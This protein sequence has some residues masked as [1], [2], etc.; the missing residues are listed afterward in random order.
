MPS[1]APMPSARGDAPLEPHE[2]ADLRADVLRYLTRQ[3]R[4]PQ[5]AMTMDTF[6]DPKTQLL[7][8]LGAATAAK[9]Q[10]CFA[11]LYG[12]ADKEIG[13]AVAIA[14]KVSAKSQDFMAAFIDQ[15]TRGGRD[16]D[17]GPRRSGGPL[18]VRMIGSA[19]SEHS[20]GWRGTLLW[21]S[22]RS[23]HHQAPGLGSGSCSGNRPSSRL[24]GAD[25]ERA[26]AARHLH[27][28]DAGGLR[29][30]Q[31]FLGDH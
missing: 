30:M 8:A 24:A 12:A 25:R 31:E 21:G 27:H 29:L 16:Q 17:D 1:G 7:V 23:S 26:H 28:V 10:H 9:C 20:P 18:R 19:S 6:L 3:A 11:T 15:T 14:A 13:A 5:E 4:A 22:R 2:M